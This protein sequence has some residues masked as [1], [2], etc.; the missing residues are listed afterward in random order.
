MAEIAQALVNASP[1]AVKACKQMVQEV[2]RR[3]ITA[4]LIAGTVKAIAD[5]RS[6]AQGKEGVQS[7]LQKRKPSWLA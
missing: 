1:D 7:F 2:A 3:D 6:S 4:E 5:I